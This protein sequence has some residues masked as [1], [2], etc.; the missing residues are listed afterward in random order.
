MGMIDFNLFQAWS[1]LFMFSGGWDNSFN[2]QILDIS[3]H[4]K[5]QTKWQE[6]VVISSLG[7]TCQLGVQYN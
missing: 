7:F 4:V 1:M 2:S 5:M 6:P 3:E